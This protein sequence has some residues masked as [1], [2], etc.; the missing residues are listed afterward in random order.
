[1]KP[2]LPGFI[3]DAESMAA[4]LYDVATKPDYP[5]QVKHEFED[6]KGLFADHQAALEKTYTAPPFP[7]PSRMAPV[8]RFPTSI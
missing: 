6:I 8:S 5:A 4:L 2:L 3:T 7:T 1:V